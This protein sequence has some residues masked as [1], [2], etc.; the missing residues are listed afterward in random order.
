MW[1][2]RVDGKLYHWENSKHHDFLQFMPAHFTRVLKRTVDES[3]IECLIKDGEAEY[4]KETGTIGIE[5]VKITE[6]D[7][8]EIKLH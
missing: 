1:I 3:E 8:P 6:V 7:E 4:F 2:I 5:I